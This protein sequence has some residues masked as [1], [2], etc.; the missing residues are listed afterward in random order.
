MRFILTILSIIG[1]LLLIA[2]AFSKDP[3]TTWFLVLDGFIGWIIIFTGAMYL[4]NCK[5]SSNRYVEI[6]PSDESI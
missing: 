6:T 2:Q 5:E 1:I 3:S 4:P